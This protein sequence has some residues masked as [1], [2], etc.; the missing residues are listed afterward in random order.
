LTNYPILLECEG[1]EAEKA[2]AVRISMRGGNGNSLLS[3]YQLIIAFFWAT[4]FIKFIDNFSI[5]LTIAFSIWV[6]LN[7]NFIWFCEGIIRSDQKIVTK[8]RRSYGEDEL[9]LLR[10]NG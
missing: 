5:L 9:R 3:V 10:N 2:A 8:Y 7:G 6:I 4:W 1:Y